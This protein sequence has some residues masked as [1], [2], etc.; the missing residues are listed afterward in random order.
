[1][2]YLGLHKVATHADFVKTIKMAMLTKAASVAGENNADL[3]QAVLNKRQALANKVFA[4]SDGQA[5]QFAFHAATFGEGVIAV[6][7]GNE[8]VYSG[9]NTLDD[10]IDSIMENIWN[11]R[12]GVT[13]AELNS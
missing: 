6:G 1:M 3:P 9:G 4:D 2:A 10:A 11:D 13:Y 7:N 5:K 8:L 12:A